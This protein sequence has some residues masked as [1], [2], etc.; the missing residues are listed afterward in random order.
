MEY[1]HRI[2]ILWLYLGRPGCGSQIG[3]DQRYEI[4]YSGSSYSPFDTIDTKICL[5]GSL[6]DFP[7]VF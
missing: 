1:I 5:Y 7:V 3:G 4:A 6:P 2:I